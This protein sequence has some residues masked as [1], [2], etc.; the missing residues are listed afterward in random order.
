MK[1]SAPDK[2]SGGLFKSFLD[3]FHEYPSQFWILVLGTFIDRLG[4]ALLFPF[5]TL[6][7]T[8]KFEIGMT[9]VGVI[10]GLFAISSF[11][12]SMIGGALTDRI[13][14]KSILLFGLVMISQAVGRKFGIKE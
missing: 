8:R 1:N 3:T 12:G 2:K 7:L 10:F 14:R 5:F 9:Q 13:G 4:G 6:Y 11:I